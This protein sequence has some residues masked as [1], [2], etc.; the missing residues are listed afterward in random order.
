MSGPPLWSSGQSSWSRGPGS[1]QYFLK[2]SGPGAQP[3]SASWVK[4]KS[5]FR[6]WSEKSRMQPHGPLTLTTRHWLL[7]QSTV[8][9]LVQFAS[10][11][12][13]RSLFACIEESVR[14]LRGGHWI[15]K[16]H[17]DFNLWSLYT[18]GQTKRRRFCREIY[19]PSATVSWGQSYKRDLWVTAP[20]LGSL[21]ERFQPSAQITCRFSQTA[22]RVWD[23]IRSVNH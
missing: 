19:L 2:N 23:F 14:F 11:H 8:A 18:T 17:A 3:Q 10:G 7:Q 16:L 20:L 9:P 13:P 21:V 12:R 1:I 4:L 6:L 22:T 15:C 5:C